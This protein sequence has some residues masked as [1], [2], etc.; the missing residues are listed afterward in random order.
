[1]S[2]M[3]V[4]TL[5]ACVTKTHHAVLIVLTPVIARIVPKLWGVF[6]RGCQGVD[7]KEHDYTT[8]EERCH[9][10]RDWRR[11]FSH[12]EES[13]S[14]PGQCPCSSCRRLI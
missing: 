8:N 6:Q 1:M 7:G 10:F 13:H 9:V 3:P 11:V 2:V 5:S 14:R 4:N 12:A